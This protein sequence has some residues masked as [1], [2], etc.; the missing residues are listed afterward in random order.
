[1]P[2]LIIQA[3][4]E[5][6]IASN[7]S[8][9]ISLVPNKV[10]GETVSFDM[11]FTEA[12]KTTSIPLAKSSPRNVNTGAN[13]AIPYSTSEQLTDRRWINGKPIYRKT[14]MV[15][16]V[17]N[18]LPD[19]MYLDQILDLDEPAGDFIFQA[20]PDPNDP[21]VGYWYDARYMQ[22]PTNYVY[23]YVD[24]SKNLIVSIGNWSG[25]FT[26]VFYTFEYTKLSDTP[27]S[28]VATTP[29]CYEIS[30]SEAKTNKV[31]FG[32]PVYTKEM[33]IGTMPNSGLAQY[34]IP[35]YDSGYD[36]WIGDGCVTKN[37]T[38]GHIL[39]FP[40]S[41]DQDYINA[42]VDNSTGKVA[43]LTSSPFGTDGFTKTRIVLEY[44]K[45]KI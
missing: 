10:N 7:D 8:D 21:T 15:E 18:G 39:S 32:Y 36:Y 40:M 20:Y 11:Y 38:T 17:G 12:G 43:L 34:D 13:E 9:R 33:D 26:R 22:I 23:V 6:P 4:G 35:D 3:I 16:I 27:T 24:Y 45:A 41:D 2:E 44:I 28:G 1:M 30:S 19:I 37:S 5:T 31:R 29:G 14:Y 25:T 42:Y